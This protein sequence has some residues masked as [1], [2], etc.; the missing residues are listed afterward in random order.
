M[1]LTQHQTYHNTKRLKN[2][3]VEVIL[4]YISISYSTVVDWGE[5]GGGSPII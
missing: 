1:F 5:Q 4:T 2:H 3:F